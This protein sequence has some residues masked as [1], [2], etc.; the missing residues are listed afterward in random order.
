M[1]AIQFGSAGGRTAGGFGATG[2]TQ[3]RTKPIP[4]SRPDIAN[5][6]SHHCGIYNPAHHISHNQFVGRFTG[7]RGSTCNTVG[8][9]GFLGG[10]QGYY[11]PGDKLGSGESYLYPADG[12]AGE[13]AAAIAQETR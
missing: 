1:S 8:R 2:K 12:P 10:L 7:V 11:H 3:P 5:R 13:Q 6:H 4:H 9:G